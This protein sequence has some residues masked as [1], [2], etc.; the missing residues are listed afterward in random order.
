VIVKGTLQ[1]PSNSGV[2][3]NG[4]VAQMTGDPYGSEFAVRVPLAM[5]ANELEVVVTTISH[6]QVSQILSL[7]RTGA[8]PYRFYVTERAGVDQIDNK[9]NIINTGNDQIVQV[10]IDFEG[11]GSIDQTLLDGFDEQISHRY[12]MEG[13]YYPQV[14]IT[15]QNGLQ[16]TL[17][18]IVNVLSASRINQIAQNQWSMMNNALMLGNHKLASDCLID[19]QREEF[20][21][22]FYQL[23][24]RFPAIIQSYSELQP[25]EM[26]TLYSSFLIN[27]DIDG[28]DRAFIVEYVRDANGVWRLAGM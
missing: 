6:K 26:N 23:L 21:A 19:R 14:T 3:V 11:D 16:F 24:P 10:D 28:V 4:I 1:A 8:S 15:D 7:N 5:G 18:Q 25:V 2:T 13:L 17:V 9:L 22:I 20:G 12:D 27:R